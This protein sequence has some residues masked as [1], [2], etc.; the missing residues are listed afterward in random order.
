MKKISM[1]TLCLTL[2]FSSHLFA[3]ENKVIGSGTIT[4]VGA[5]VEGNCQMESDKNTFKTNC[6]NGDKMEESK[7]NLV[8]NK[9]FNSKLINNKGSMDIKWINDKLAI[10]NVAYN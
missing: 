10:M 2:L 3:N 4:F 1:A 9:Q 8:P 6:W 7:Y 5:I